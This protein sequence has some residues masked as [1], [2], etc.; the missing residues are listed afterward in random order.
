MRAGR[1][2]DKEIKGMEGAGGK[3]YEIDGRANET[4]VR[5]RLDGSCLGDEFEARRGRGEGGRGGPGG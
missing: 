1:W 2:P 3:K 5:F 4:T